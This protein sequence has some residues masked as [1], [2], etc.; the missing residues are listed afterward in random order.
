MRNLATLALL[1]LASFTLGG[2]LTS[3][4][5]VFN[6]TQAVAALGDGGHYQTYEVT[7]AG[8]YKTEER[9]DVRRKGRIYEF[10]NTRG[11][12]TAVSFYPLPNNRFAGQIL[13]GGGDYAY[14]MMRLEGST[15]YMHVADCE[16]QDKE[17]LAALGV[18]VRNG[19]CLLDKVADPRALFA[20]LSFGPPASKM[21]P[22]VEE[23][24]RKR[25]AQP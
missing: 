22:A 17:R 4:K 18:Q 10:T 14:V 24:R 7:D 15:A 1:A 21:E 6:E 11:I 23:R 2:C 8:G 20:A 9:I 5:P 13:S 19:Q 12:S 3:K 25:H 16:K